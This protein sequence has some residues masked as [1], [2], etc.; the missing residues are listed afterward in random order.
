[1]TTRR[2]LSSPP[3]ALRRDEVQAM[4]GL[5]GDAAPWQERLATSWVVDVLLFAFENY[6][7][8]TNNIY[9]IIM[10]RKF[11]AVCFG[12]GGMAINLSFSLVGLSRSNQTYITIYIDI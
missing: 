10:C 9:L 3:A 1:M 6:I 12:H 2:R 8:K 7:Q 5:R 4:A 11:L